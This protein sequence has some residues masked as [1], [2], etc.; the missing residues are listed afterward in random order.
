MLDCGKYHI[1]YVVIGI[2]YEDV[3]MNENYLLEPKNKLSRTTA[4]NY[5]MVNLVRICFSFG[6]QQAPGLWPVSIL[7]FAIHKL[8]VVSA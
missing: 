4:I 5:I 6:Q 1:L 7:M 2:M 3:F 8:P